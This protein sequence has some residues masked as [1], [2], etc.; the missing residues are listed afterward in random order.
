MKPD[1]RLAWLGRLAV[2]VPLFAILIAALWYAVYAW[3]TMEGPDIP[4]SG[5]VAMIA[6]VILSLVVGVGLMSLLFYSRRHGYDE[7]A[8]MDERDR[9]SD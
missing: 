9:G 7:R 8:H 2:F 4:A 1:G 5:Y 3:R 6:G